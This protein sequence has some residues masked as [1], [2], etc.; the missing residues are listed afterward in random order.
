MPGFVPVTDDM[1]AA[2]Q[3]DRAYR[4][5]LLNRHLNALIVELNRLRDSPRAK[6][7]RV[8]GQ[9]AQGA[10]MAL[11]LAEILQKTGE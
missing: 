8:A 6:E 2:A 9:I 10:A 11:Q 7:P 5:E 1:L 4:R 3:A